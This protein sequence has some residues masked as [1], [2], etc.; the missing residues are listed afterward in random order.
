MNFNFYR[1]SDPGNSTSLNEV[2]GILGAG[3]DR[4]RPRAP[5]PACRHRAD[6]AD[7][8]HGAVAPG[9]GPAA[10]RRGLRQG[11]RGERSI[12]A[13]SLLSCGTAL[14]RVGSDLD[15]IRKFRRMPAK[16]AT[17]WFISSPSQHHRR[18]CWVLRV[19]V[20]LPFGYILRCLSV[21]CF[22]AVSKFTL[23]NSW[24]NSVKS[25]LVP[26]TFRQHLDLPGLFLRRSVLRMD[27]SIW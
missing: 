23:L 25:I 27:P 8:W 1:I 19:L 9:P 4:R 13:A 22:P 10:P 17:F 16:F 7:R 14:L 20:S 26:A 24:Q 18:T 3:R 12:A 11:G 15:S 5:V 2:S 21:V 6:V